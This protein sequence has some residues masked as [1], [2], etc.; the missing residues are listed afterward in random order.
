MVATQVIEQSLDLDFD[1]IVS[2]YAPIDLLI[3]RIGR[4]HRHQRNQRPV[5]L[6]EPVLWLMA[7][8]SLEPIPNFGLDERVYDRYT[9][10]R[11]WLELREAPAFCLPA[12]T[13]ELIEAVYDESPTWGRFSTDMQTEL[14]MAWEKLRESRDKAHKEA[15]VR[16]IAEPSDH[17]F[18]ATS[19]KA[20]NEDDPRLNDALRA[21]TR[22]AQPTITLVC[23][24]EQADGLHP[25][26]HTMRSTIHSEA[27]SLSEQPSRA[28][29]ATLM[30]A[31]VNV[32]R[33]EIVREFASQEVPSGWR[34]HSV[35]KYCRPAVF[36]NDV[37]L[38]G[39][40]RLTLTRELGLHIEKT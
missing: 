21:L 19:G 7:P 9:L 31:A 37:L 17:R 22:L 2:D 5:G 33:P 12:K 6:D 3:Q 38:V 10:L 29:T 14:V 34:E 39:D 15:N 4:L 32:T 16:L 18:M 1:L 25:L 28:K 27:I 20:L 24:A 36:V 13:R 11:S 26:Y 35:L 8:E 23:L 40:F 30:R